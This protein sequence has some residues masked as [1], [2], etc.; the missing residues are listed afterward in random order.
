MPVD[1]TLRDVV[2]PVIAELVAR[3]P[4]AAGRAMLV[5]AL[6]RDVLHRE[7]GHDFPLRS[8]SDLDLALAVDRWDGF[9]EVARMLP[10]RRTAAQVRFQLAG[11]KVDLIPFGGIEDPD[12]AVPLEASA[13]PLD[14]LGFVDVWETAR[15][16]VLSD[17]LSVRIPT[18]A[19]YAMLKLAAWATRSRVGEYKDAGDLAC[20]M[21]W[22]QRS[23]AISDR[24]Y[25]E[26]Q[27]T[28]ILEH[29]WTRP[30]DASLDEHTVLL[31]VDAT[32]LLSPA[33]RA[34]LAARWVDV[35]DRLLATYLTNR[36][37]PGW[38]TPGQPG[39]IE[40]ARSLRVGIVLAA[41][42]RAPS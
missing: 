37:L 2:E 24:L 3:A 19:G 21:Y 6:C 13:E 15:T 20:V 18:V 12:G 16:L 5:G 4:H 41:T 33:R 38:S 7:A 29:V 40:H 22:Y 39:L 27:G 34:A 35:D 36:S 42:G 31:A 8:T 17:G 25:S 9:G 10:R 30:E 11:T 1:R 28:Q 32:S 23:A 14:V 26:E